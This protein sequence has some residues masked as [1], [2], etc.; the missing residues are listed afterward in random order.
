MLLAP[1]FVSLSGL[2]VWLDTPDRSLPS[3]LLELSTMFGRSIGMY[4]VR[5]RRRLF[6]H[7][8]M[9][10]LGL[11]LMIL[12]LFGFVVLR[13]VCFGLILEPVVPLKLA[14]LP[15]LAEGS[16]TNS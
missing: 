15:F 2:P 6:L 14:V 10:S 5:F 7:F 1:L 11:L 3:R 12:G 8:G 13:R 4:S 9:P 16:V